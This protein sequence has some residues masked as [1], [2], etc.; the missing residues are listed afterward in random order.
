MKIPFFNQKILQQKIP[1]P[2]EIQCGLQGFLRIAT[3]K[4]KNAFRGFHDF[5]FGRKLSKLRVGSNLTASLL[6][7]GPQLLKGFWWVK[8]LADE[9]DGNL[10]VLLIACWWHQEH[11][12]TDTPGTNLQTTYTPKVLRVLSFDPG[13]L[14]CCIFF[15]SRKDLNLILSDTSRLGFVYMVTFYIV[16]LVNHHCSPS[17]G[18]DCWSSRPTTG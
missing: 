7:T 9:M 10:W 5:C 13:T 17:L 16:P 2:L 18:E 3:S 6:T 1:K 14:G 4:T 12:I 8:F 15:L 11:H